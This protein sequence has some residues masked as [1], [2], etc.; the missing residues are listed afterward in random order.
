MVG[1]HSPRRRSR[2]PRVS[3][4]A[5]AQLGL[6]RRRVEAARREEDVAVEPEVGDSST[7]RSSDSAAPASAASTP[8][9]PT[10]RAAAAA[11]GLHERRDVGACRTVARPLGDRP[12]EPRRE[13]GLGTGVRRRPA[14]RT[15]RRTAS[16]SQSSRSSSTGEGAPRGLALVPQLPPRAAPELGL[17][18]S[19]RVRQRLLVHPGEHEHAPGLGVLDDRRAEVR[20]ASRSGTPGRGAPRAARRGAPDARGGST[21]GAPPAPPAARRRRA[22]PSRLRPTRSRARAR[23]GRRRG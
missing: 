3:A 18:P 10:L 9:S 16:P 4:S 11:A 21:Q 6:D 5:A 13:A 22:R 14:G 2:L 1:G 15:R 19:S 17:A 8:S 20:A 7:R 23:P 12:P